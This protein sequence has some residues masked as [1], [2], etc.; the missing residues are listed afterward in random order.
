MENVAPQ[1]TFNA[2]WLKLLPAH[3]N[4]RYFQD[5]VG[6]ISAI[7]LPPIQYNLQAERQSLSW[8]KGGA[9]LGSPVG[10]YLFIWGQMEYIMEM[11]IV[12]NDNIYMLFYHH[13]IEAPCQA[14][15]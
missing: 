3:K 15:L 7:F 10:L 9:E 13:C 2:P 14:T 5:H 11:E 12:D 8:M 6:T 4:M 1:S